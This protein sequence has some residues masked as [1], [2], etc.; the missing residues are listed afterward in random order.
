MSGT[1]ARA[2][3][4]RTSGADP[5][6]VSSVGLDVNQSTHTDTSSN[7]SADKPQRRA[8]RGNYSSA[9]VEITGTS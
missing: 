4:D 5:A 6:L 1:G 2:S 8:T 7:G 3:A 9:A